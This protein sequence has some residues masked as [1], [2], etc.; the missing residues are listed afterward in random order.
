MRLGSF[1]IYK[2]VFFISSSACWFGPFTPWE[3]VGMGVSHTNSKIL[4]TAV[5]RFLPLATPHRHK[6]PPS[7]GLPLLQ[8]RILLD[9]LLQKGSNF[10]LPLRR[11]KRKDGARVCIVIDTHLPVCGVIY[12]GLPRQLLNALQAGAFEL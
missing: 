8:P 10:G 3:K 12:G 9:Q 7:D 4:E 1:R 11:L 6:R 5:D 2:S